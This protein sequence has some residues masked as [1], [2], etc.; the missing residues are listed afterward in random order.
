MDFAPPSS[1]LP[2]LWMQQ[3]LTELACRLAPDFQGDSHALGEAL[4]KHFRAWDKD[5]NGL[6]TS[7]ELL[8]GFMDACGDCS[9][10][11]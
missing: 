8:E 1:D 7:D 5:E 3:A 2:D 11:H 6:L 10:G 4:L 9:L